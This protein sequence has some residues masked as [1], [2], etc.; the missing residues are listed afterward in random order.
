MFK[1][2]REFAL[3][4]SFVDLA[5]GLIVGAAVGKVVTSLVDDVIMAP[6]GALLGR[7][8]FS[9]LFF[10]IDRGGRVHRTLAEAKAAG[11][12]YVAVW[13]LH[14]HAHRVPDRHG[15]RVPHRQGDEQAAPSA[16]D[17]HEAVPVLRD[18][19]PKGGQ[20]LSRVHL[21]ARKPLRPAARVR[22]RRVAPA[23]A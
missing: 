5:V 23:F 15:G 1:E 8:D 22:T 16:G 14:Q 3:K 10:A 4:G 11:V 20:P 21:S 13:L 19:H 17:D 9:G 2:F 18:R 6:I 12:P 7:V